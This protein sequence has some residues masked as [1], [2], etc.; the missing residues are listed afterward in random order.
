MQRHL[1]SRRQLLRIGALGWA[2]ASLPNLLRAE[3][4]GAGRQKE[5]GDR[6]N[7]ETGAAPERKRA[8]A[9][10]LVFYYGGPSHLETWDPKPEAPAEIRGE[11]GTIGTS[12]P[13]VR[14]GEHLPRCAKVMHR[15][16]LV[17]SVHHPMTNHNAAAAETLTGRTPPG[18]DQEL[19]QDDA[20]SFPCYGSALTCALRDET[21]V[22]PHVAL[23]HVMTNVVTL[24]G[25]K[26]GF[27]GGAYDP[28]QVSCNPNA[29]VCRVPD[30][31][32]PASLTLPRLEHRQSLQRLVDRQLAAGERAAA[33]AK[34]AD[35]FYR[36]AF[37]LLASEAVRRAFDLDRE[38]PATRE[39]YGRTVHGQ[40]LL[41]ARRLVE[42]GVRFVSVY[43]GV[44]N[45]QDAN[46]DSHQ[47]VFARHRDHL[48][49]PADQGLSALVEDLHE[50]GMLEETLVIA[51][52]EFGRTPQINGG[53]GRDHWPHCFTVALA[54]GGVTGGAV[55]GASDAWGAHPAS[56]PVT[57]GD[58]AATLFW[59]FGLDPATELR[60]LTDRPFRL[61]E[62][63]PLR[64]L[65]GG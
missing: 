16:A 5:K 25:Q 4:S 18:G 46:W 33:T 27:L 59:R 22:L 19:L 60:D 62:G 43:D 15:L 38:A 17:R 11:F 6:Q 40:S 48:L 20:R 39:R 52:G 30:L 32:L 13:G 57:P 10:I 12:V 7:G 28:L 29:P 36:R 55:H 42:T 56:N 50:R 47:A 63:E 54:G 2:G 41:L 64:A 34:A 45:G 37:D 21:R 31:E 44:T 61:A 8:R 24:P 58:L 51:L 53:G 23:P 26:A 49:P 3:A 1:P 65:F 14:I 9:C 35:A